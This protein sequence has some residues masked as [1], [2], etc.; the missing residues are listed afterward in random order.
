MRATRAVAVLLILCLGLH[1]GKEGSVRGQLTNETN[2]NGTDKID[3]FLEDLNTTI[4]DDDPR[5]LPDILEQDDINTVLNSTVF[6]TVITV[7][8]NSSTTISIFTEEMNSTTTSLP[9]TVTT[10]KPFDRL[11]R[12][13]DAR[14]KA[15]T[16]SIPTTTAYLS[17][18]MVI[19]GLILVIA[20]TFLIMFGGTI[21]AVF[22]CRSKPAGR[23]SR[24]SINSASSSLTHRSQQ[25]GAQRTQSQ[26]RILP[27]PPKQAETTTAS[28][29]SGGG[30]T[31]SDEPHQRLPN[32]NNP[33]LEPDHISAT[34]FRH[35]GPLHIPEIK[36]NISLRHEL[37][38]DRSKSVHASDHVQFDSKQFVVRDIGPGVE[39][40]PNDDTNKPLDLGIPPP[41]Q[42]DSQPRPPM[43]KPPLPATVQASPV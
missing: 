2:T 18:R 43:P 29:G 20:L 17:E 19:T 25:S 39:V 42:D 28:N 30:V 27:N 35:H 41:I 8:T 40:N 36:S 33:G 5:N 32:V 1:L 12:F 10:P 14:D 15:T 3:V 24:G 34:H 37:D 26:P 22:A 7:E 13:T 31:G 21:F 9:S 4:T 11:T 6:T 16:E 23:D 38:N